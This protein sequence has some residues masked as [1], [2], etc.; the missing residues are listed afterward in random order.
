M[1]KLIALLLLTASFFPNRLQGEQEALMRLHCLSLRF[2]PASTEVQGVRYTLQLG[3]GM[4][5]ATNSNGEVGPLL[6]GG[7][8]THGCRMDLQSIAL[9]RPLTGDFY[10][11]I[12][13]LG[14]ANVNGVDDFFEVRLPV[15]SATSKGAFTDDSTGEQGSV[16][17]TWNRTANSP[18]GTCQLQLADSRI[19]LS[20]THAFSL[21]E[22]DGDY[23]FNPGITNVTGIARLADSASALF[24]GSLALSKTNE[25]Y[26]T[27]EGGSWTNMTGLTWTFLDSTTGESIARH[28]TN[29]VG[30]LD[31]ADGDLSTPQPDFAT[32]LVVISDGSDTNGNGIPDLSDMS[33]SPAIAP[34]VAL[35]GANGKWTLN[36]RGALGSR[37]KVEENWTLR[38]SNW[39]TIASVVLTNKIQ[40]VTLP[41]PPS[42][43]CFWRVRSP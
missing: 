6:N 19:S 27:V 15:N 42:P 5:Q 1:Q 36:V 28:G 23:R 31:F 8:T 3:T 26:L 4:R 24:S 14:D 25:N 37:L 35:K 20:F 33:L 9:P 41:T 18:V 2:Q 16:T 40:T 11:N 17:A 30:F 32:W 34:V 7:P 13:R 22:F 38:E 43:S 39:V 12:P 21:L 29:Y 10:L